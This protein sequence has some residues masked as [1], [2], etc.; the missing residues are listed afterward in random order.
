LKQT[1]GWS[2]FHAIK[3]LTGDA[4]PRTCNIDTTPDGSVAFIGKGAPLTKKQVSW[5]ADTPPHM[6]GVQKQ[7]SVNRADEGR[8]MHA[9]EG[10]GSIFVPLNKQILEKVS[11]RSVARRSV[12]RSVSLLKQTCSPTLHTSPVTRSKTSLN[13]AILSKEAV[14]PDL[15]IPKP[16][17]GNST[18]DATS[19]TRHGKSEART[20][21]LGMKG[22]GVMED[23]TSKK[24]DF[25]SIVYDPR[26]WI[27]GVERSFDLG[28]DD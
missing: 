3:D 4:W 17:G 24:L 21:R 6:V 10:V 15:I 12:T 14:G 9:A 25:D 5:A 28:F 26:A 27:P 20:S 13:L 23:T 7:Q 19:P 16:C 22:I 1:E 8:S 2:S 11:P 18:K